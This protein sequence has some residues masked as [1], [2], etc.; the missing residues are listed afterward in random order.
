MGTTAS[1]WCSRGH[2]IDED[3]NASEEDPEGSMR[4][5]ANGPPLGMKTP[6]RKTP[7]RA[8]H[9]C[10]KHGVIWAEEEAETTYGSIDLVSSV[11]QRKLRKIKEKD[12]D[13][14]PHMRGFNRLK[15]VRTKY[16]D[17]PPLSVEE[18]KE[19]LENLD[20]SFYAF[21]NEETGTFLLVLC[22]LYKRKEGGYGLIIPKDEQV[23]NTASSSEHTIETAIA[24]KASG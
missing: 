15:I 16:F 18:A 8:W 21:R 1:F 23:P 14:G 13:H 4:T 9:R 10:K 5:P 6:T 2:M 11:L 17:M 19:Q 7:K 20:H 22:I 24:E 12:T 3:G